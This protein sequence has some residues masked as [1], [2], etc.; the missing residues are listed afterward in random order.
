[1][2]F[3]LQ[4]QWQAMRAERVRQLT[5]ESEALAKLIDTDRAT[6]AAGKLT[7]Q[8]A[9]AA[10][11]AQV[12][13]MLHGKGDYYFV[14]D[15]KGIVVGHPN[16]KI[17]GMDFM[18]QVDSKGFGW[19]PDVMPRAIRDGLAEVEYYYPHAGQTDAALKLGVYRYYEP[20]H[21]IIGTGVYL[22]DL[23]ASFGALAIKLGGVA[24][25]ALALMLVAA[26]LVI[27]SITRPTQA[28]STAMRDLA[29]GNMEGAVP[30]GGSLAETR[31]MADA[32]QVFKTAAIEKTQL[33]AEAIEQRQIAEAQ[34]LRHEAEREAA[35][36][37]QK[38]VVDA[39]AGGLAQLSSGD[40]TV[41]LVQAFA[42][43]YEQLREDFNAAT[44][45]L[46][47][48]MGMIIANTGTI[49]SGTGEIS[50]AADDLSRRTEQQ[51]ASL[52]E[53]AAALDEITATVRKTADGANAA[54]HVVTAAKTEAEHGEVVVR[55]AVTAMSEIEKSAKEISQII[56]VI[57]EIAFQTNL[58][59]LNAGVE[60]ARAGDA[61]RGFA[62]VASEVRALAQRS[63]EA[64]KEIKALI[65]PAG[66]CGP[67]RDA[68]AG[69]R[70][71]PGPD[72]GPGDA[73]HRRCRGDRGQRA[74]AGKRPRRGEHRHQPDGPGDAAK[75]C[76][77]RAEHRSKP[78]AGPGDRG[79]DAIDRPISAWPGSRHRRIWRQSDAAAPPRPGA[80]SESRGAESQPWRSCQADA[81]PRSGG[82]GRVLN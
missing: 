13:S 56:G 19:I 55:D 73:D 10:A 60:A 4:S 51:A 36:A 9:Q 25:G 17:V 8:A 29:A 66:A 18:K 3:A 30:T 67:W 57:D 71:C 54:Q 44:T 47:T 11:L 61:G 7:E 2:G 31:A 64:A 81:G 32:V 75:R 5:T 76:H 58:L 69:N 82:M 59:A 12:V 6:V 65:A 80:A 37:S 15:T 14:L 42:P 74:G 46:Q 63:A 28:L 40:L 16:A 22:D 21:W 23:D 33:A 77:G 72:P 20:W 52:E 27:R 41:R 39:V 53:T 70:R 26:T 78:L 79:A 62:V 45:Q 49:R 24:L 38:S 48:A 35:A 43:D 1:M 34:R 50:Q 68:G